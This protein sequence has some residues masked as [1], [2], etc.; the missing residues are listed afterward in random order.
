MQLKINIQDE[1]VIELQRRLGYNNRT[2]VI[3]DALAI[4][5]W[6]VQES[7]NGRVILSANR[8]ARDFSRLAMNPLEKLAA[9]TLVRS[10][11]SQE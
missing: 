6:P 10:E 3:R 11:G 1:L 4:L 7:A 5:N 8:D 9:G 2:D